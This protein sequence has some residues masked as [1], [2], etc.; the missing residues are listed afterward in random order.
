[1]VESS[2]PRPDLDRLCEEII[3]DT[4]ARDLLA[5]A[6]IVD[7]VDRLRAGHIDQADLVATVFRAV[8]SSWALAGGQQ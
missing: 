1:M 2:A 6:V 4:A 8:H 3:L 7:A 5:T